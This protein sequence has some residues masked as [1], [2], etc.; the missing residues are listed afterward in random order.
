MLSPKKMQEYVT[1]KIIANSD[2]PI[3]SGLLSEKLIR[4]GFDVSEATA[5]RMLRELDIKG[6]TEK[7]G[8]RGRILTEAGKKRLNKLKQEKEI[9]H[10]SKE[11][12]SVVRVKDKEELLDVLIA[13]KVIEKE[14][15][16]LAAINATKEDIKN[17]KEILSS[18]EKHFDDFVKGAQD[19][20]KFHK[21]ISKLAGNRV[22]D[23]AMDLIRQDGQLS[24]VL[25]F[26]RKKVKSTVVSDHKKI[27]E[28]ISKK[29]P[30]EAEK[31]MT[32]HINSL[33]KDVNKYWE[34][35]E[36]EK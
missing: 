25:G 32:D 15:A 6:Y 34:L 5:G 1:L 21:Y 7:V 14:L 16:R 30:G 19:D 17:L 10:Y 12:L 29:D 18:H 2:T 33:I 11:F 8:F 24:P 3:G 27:V 22:L 31:A 28:A 26:I 36:K 4:E 9:N 13:R 35:Y 20:L 23:A